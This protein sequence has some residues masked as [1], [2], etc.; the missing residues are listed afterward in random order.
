MLTIEENFTIISIMRPN[1]MAVTTGDAIN[2]ANISIQFV[3]STDCGNAILSSIN[4]PSFE[5]PEEKQRTTLTAPAQYPNGTATA[6]IRI[7]RPYSCQLEGR[8]LWPFRQV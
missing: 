3:M 8:A 5:A 7:A 1:I 4:V 6:V 2:A